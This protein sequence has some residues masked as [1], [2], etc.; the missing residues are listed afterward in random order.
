MYQTI[1][2][3]LY[4]DNACHILVAYTFVLTLNILTFNLIKAVLITAILSLMKEAADLVL[5]KTVWK[6]NIKDLLFDSIGIGLAVLIVC[7]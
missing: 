6:E 4:T 5:D 1:K 3:F 2:K 7:I